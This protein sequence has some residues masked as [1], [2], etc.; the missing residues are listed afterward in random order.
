[1]EWWNGGGDKTSSQSS[2]TPSLQ[3]SNT[4]ILRSPPGFTLIEL[5][6]V[7]AIMSIILV[8]AIPM[9]QGM[10]KKDM[11]SAAAQ[12]RATLRLAR[13]YAVTQRQNVYVVFP[14]NRAP[15]VSTNDVDKLLR[16][17][18]VLMTNSAS[19]GFQY[20]TDWK[21]L[22][23]GIYFD[24]TPT[25]SASIWNTVNHAS[26]YRFPFPQESSGPRFMPVLNFRP[27]GRCYRYRSSSDTWSS[28][29]HSVYF[30]TSRFYTKSANN[31]RLVRGSD[32]PGVTNRIRVR[33]RTG[34]IDV[35]QDDQTY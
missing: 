27:D 17:Y 32:I 15:D 29:N 22:P 1:M 30:T 3:H 19:G 11:G 10:G 31:E 24:D 4:P 25:L 18:A 20:I 28:D 13:Q 6:A 34:Q 16:S 35:H 9:F 26:P 12:L 21:Y 23:Q 5:L 8:A 14:D 2:N 33:G 7:V